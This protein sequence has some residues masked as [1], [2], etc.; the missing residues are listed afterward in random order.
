MAR[1]FKAPV[2]QPLDYGHD[3]PAQFLQNKVD[4]LQAKQDADRTSAAKLMDNSEWEGRPVDAKDSQRILDERISRSNSIL[5]NKDGSRRDL[6]QS[7]IQKEIQTEINLRNKE[8]TVGGTVYTIKENKAKED[9]YRTQIAAL[10]KTGVGKGY[11]DERANF[12]NEALVDPNKIG[13]PTIGANGELYSVEM[14]MLAANVEQQNI[15]DNYAKEVK[16]DTAL[17][18]QVNTIQA[19]Y[20][21]AQS[22]SRMGYDKNG[23]VVDVNHAILS[24]MGMT[25]D[26][27]QSKAGTTL[28]KD[29]F[30]YLKSTSVEFVSGFKI[31][32]ATT[33]SLYNDNRVIGDL[34][35]QYMQD[36]E[37]GDI[38]E[39][40]N[41]RIERLA[42]ASANKY[43]KMKFTDQKFK[44]W[45]SYQRIEHGFQQKLSKKPEGI[46]D[47]TRL[48]TGQYT[49]Q[50]NVGL[51]MMMSNAVQGYNSSMKNANAV[52]SSNSSS[53]NERATAV[54]GVKQKIA[55]TASVA[56]LGMEQYSAEYQQDF[57]AANPEFKGVLNLNREDPLA[58][59]I[60]L[61]AAQFCKM[62]GA[63]PEGFKKAVQILESEVSSEIVIG[64]PKGDHYTIKNDDVKLHNVFSGSIFNNKKLMK[65]L[66]TISSIPTTK[67][68]NYRIISSDPPENK[69]VIPNT[70][71]TGWRGDVVVNS[72]GMFADLGPNALMPFGE[73]YPSDMKEI[74]KKFPN[75]AAEYRK[76]AADGNRFLTNIARASYPRQ[77]YS[78]GLNITEL[79]ALYD[80]EYG[81]V[82]SGLEKLE[83]DFGKVFKNTNNRE[84]G[85]EFN[86]QV[87]VTGSGQ[88]TGILP[89]DYSYINYINSQAGSGTGGIFSHAARFQRSDGNSISMQTAVGEAISNDADLKSSTIQD[90]KLI[91]GQTGVSDDKL[92]GNDALMPI[93]FTMEYKGTEKS[94]QG[95]QIE[96][97]LFTDALYSGTGQA[98]TINLINNS[99]NAQLSNITVKEKANQ[100]L[101][102]AAIEYYNVHFASSTAATALKHLRVGSTHTLLSN[103]NKAYTVKRTGNKEYQVL[104][105]MNKVIP[106]N[107]F[108]HKTAGNTLPS[109][110]DVIQNIGTNFMMLQQ[111][112]SYFTSYKRVYDKI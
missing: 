56:Y 46:R 24:Q 87:Q 71:G 96:L 13:K 36:G 69:F 39:Y 22:G 89:V 26:F 81:G 67:E 59:L 48:N 16:E 57:E 52:Y 3:I 30:G 41:N 47:T 58:S 98:S 29:R 37:T 1:Y 35:S 44:D 65:N 34:K 11:G 90:F 108:W 9:A 27:L 99:T 83:E 12:L 106:D 77:R 50:Q 61:R 84:V 54:N 80:G 55:K 60:Q 49:I 25:E 18:D 17:I 6:L 62:S 95:R 15:S 7:G 74:E 102:K 53:Q 43:M 107:R 112:N 8:E 109:V 21:T 72:K 40:I 28:M 93:R 10:R 32:A 88:N 51:G 110:T 33:Q 76:K 70:S 66:A 42:M 94:L 101:D 104:D 14:T 78:G 75:K 86:Y 92:P 31:M 100:V 2:V 73:I 4:K 45:Q 63:G 38:N 85:L 97:N 79:S 19:L 68:Y 111:G 20:G 64:N 23:G 5:Y 105:Q 91:P 103:N 82:A